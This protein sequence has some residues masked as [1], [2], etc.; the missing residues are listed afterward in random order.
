MCL[1]H[2]SYDGWLGSHW[3]VYGFFGVGRKRR[4]TINPAGV[5]INL[6]GTHYTLCIVKQPE[7]SEAK[8]E[9]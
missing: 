3:H 6:A 5:T 4:M 8:K 7:K 1:E 9:K 2:T